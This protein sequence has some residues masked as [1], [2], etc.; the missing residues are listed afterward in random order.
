[1]KTSSR[2]SQ[3]ATWRNETGNRPEFRHQNPK[4]KKDG[5]KEFRSRGPSRRGSDA[6]PSDLKEPTMASPRTHMRLAKGPHGPGWIFPRTKFVQTVQDRDA[7]LN[8]SSVDVAC[9]RLDV[10]PQLLIVN[11]PLTIPSPTTHTSYSELCTAPVVQTGA[12]PTCTEIVPTIK[13][14]LVRCGSGH[15]PMSEP[16]ELPTCELV[17][18]SGSFRIFAL[19]FVLICLILVGL[20]G[21]QGGS[22]LSLFAKV[23]VIGLLVTLLGYGV[24]F[25]APKAEKHELE[26]NTSTRGEPF[27]E[28][29][30]PPV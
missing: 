25:R 16:V 11:S 19:S 14:V 6:P 20:F 15:L 7:L 13:P 1:M 23:V 30:S 4:P 9:P 12:M 29:I 10:S 22:L 18:A 27:L 8:V 2:P 3:N 26:R 28:R 17:G 5:K 21:F 24:G